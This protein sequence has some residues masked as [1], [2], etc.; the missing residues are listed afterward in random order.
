M[1]AS[2]HSEEVYVVDVIKHKNSEKGPASVHMPT[3]LKQMVADFI[4]TVRPMNI[5]NKPNTKRV[6]TSTNGRKVKNVSGEAYMYPIW[7][8]ANCH[9]WNLTDC[10]KAL[11]I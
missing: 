5:E 7:G 9:E 8:L 1:R 3:S 10:R 11:A 6:F 2:E 4:R